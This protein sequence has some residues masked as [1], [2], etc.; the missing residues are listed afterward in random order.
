MSAI[1]IPTTSVTIMLGISP[2]MKTALVFVGFFLLVVAAASDV[3]YGYQVHLGS[4]RS[5]NP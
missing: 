2:M 4:A 5:P 3:A 1:L